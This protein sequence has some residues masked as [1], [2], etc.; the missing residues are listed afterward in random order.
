MTGGPSISRAPEGLNG[1]KAALRARLLAARRAVAAAHKAEWDQRIGAQLQQW[2]AARGLRE[3][4]VFW[5]LRGEPDLSA[6]YTALAE[7]GLRLL[8]P[9]VI[10]RDSALAFSDWTPGEAML[11]DPMGVAV[12][13]VLRLRARPAAIVVPCL[14]FNAAGYRVGYGGGYYDRTL[15]AAPRPASVG[16]AYRCQQVDF[17]PDPHDIALDQILTE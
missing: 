7:A 13:A 10:A 14:G 15:A 12:P 9:V 6:A 5:P 11:R 3:L 2:C 16:V 1:D 17:R 8:L 4:A